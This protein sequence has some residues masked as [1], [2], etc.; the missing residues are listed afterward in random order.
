VASKAVPV[1]LGA[2]GYLQ[3]ASDTGGSSGRALSTCGCPE[4]EVARCHAKEA[5]RWRHACHATT[6]QAPYPR[7]SGQ[8]G[9][10]A[11][12]Q[13][14][15]TLVLSGSTRASRQ[16]AAMQ[17]QCMRIMAARQAARDRKGP[18]CSSWWVWG[19]VRCQEG[20]ASSSRSQCRGAVH[21]FRRRAAE[22]EQRSSGK[23]GRV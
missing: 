8:G 7:T 12:T 10:Y 15:Q 22:P 19:S 20:R 3:R 14:Q 4:G 16:L 9:V 2:S 23:R 17:W 18:A 13:R 1:R 6:A 5:T 11:C 21:E